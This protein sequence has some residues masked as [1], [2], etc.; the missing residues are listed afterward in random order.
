VA[1]LLLLRANPLERVEAFDAIDLV[2]LRGRVIDRA[3]LAAR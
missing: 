3:G 2:I 1:N